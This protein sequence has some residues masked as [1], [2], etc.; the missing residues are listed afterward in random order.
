MRLKKS[1]RVSIEQVRIT[2]EGDG[3]I[4][5]HADAGIGLEQLR[6]GSR[7]LGLK[8]VASKFGISP[9]TLRRSLSAL[10]FVE[11]IEGRRPAA[12]R[13]L[14]SAPVA[15]I[16]HIARWHAYDPVGA[17]AAAQRVRQGRYTIAALEA[18]E[19]AA[20]AVNKPERVGQSLVTACRER[21]G[22]VLCKQLTGFECETRA[23]LRESKSAVDFRFRPNGS[24]KWTIA[25]IIIGPYR[26]QSLYKLRLD[27][28]LIKALGLTLLYER[29][30][31]VAPTSALKRQ[32]TAWL[33]A[34]K[35]VLPNL[36]IP[37]ITPV[38]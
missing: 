31:L 2:R 7:E 4:V 29:V 3:A 32:C 28:W 33:R 14:R 1:T 23:S 35:L 27:D 18:A 24:R 10:K 16:E 6:F 9:Q 15:A 38:P 8:R 22:P 20:R 5:D 21:V 30:I 36:E 12:K 19:H 25:A 13:T 11:A 26:D 37:V 17:T 34:H